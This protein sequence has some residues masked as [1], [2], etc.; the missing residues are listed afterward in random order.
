MSDVLSV[1]DG[2]L[3]PPVIAVTAFAAWVSAVVLVR[4]AR[5]AR[6]SVGALTERAVIAVLIAVML[7]IYAVVAA[8]TDIGSSL[9]D[10]D[11]GRRF[12]RLVV[13]M[14]GA[15][16]VVW[17]YLWLRGRLGPRGLG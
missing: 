5:H 1:V 9:F 13:V 4:A 14:V 15:I 17:C 12:V 7:T 3:S 8:N 11:T 6:P 10:Q 16:P 2:L